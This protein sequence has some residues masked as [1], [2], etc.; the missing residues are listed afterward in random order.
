MNEMGEIWCYIPLE[1][2]HWKTEIGSKAPSPVPPLVLVHTVLA[3]VQS[4]DAIQPWALHLH[5]AFL[6]LM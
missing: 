2:W 4:S 3:P 1:I 6:L 5:L